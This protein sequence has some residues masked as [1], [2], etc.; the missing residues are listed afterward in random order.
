VD[1][2]DNNHDFL[3]AFEEYLSK[4]YSRNT[5]RIR[6][7]YTKK[8]YHVL[9]EDNSAM[10]RD[11]LTIEN[12][13]KSLNVMKSLTALSKYLGCYDRWH[14]MPR[15]YNMKW[16]TGDSSIQSFERFCNNGLNYDTLLQWI[17]Q[18]IQKHAQL[19]WAI[20]SGLHV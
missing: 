2:D 1:D 14:E 19:L 18:M 17:R 5:A 3:L 15:R 7:F 11:F 13:E 20:S 12:G 8:F 9:L 4:T 10:Q 6:L 16:S